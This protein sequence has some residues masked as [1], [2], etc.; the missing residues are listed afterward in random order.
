M[1]FHCS[2][3]LFQLSLLDSSI[4]SCISV[5][6]PILF[7]VALSYAHTNLLICFYSFD[8]S[9]PI[10]EKIE[11]LYIEQMFYYRATSHWIE[12]NLQRLKMKYKMKPVGE[13]H[14]SINS[15]SEM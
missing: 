8:L 4:I 3:C 2:I 1:S 14:A 15:W 11:N 10:L 6:L 9:C 12:K 5:L 13:A 7:A